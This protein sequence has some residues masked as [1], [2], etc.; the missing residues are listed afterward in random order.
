M[1][2]G[3]LAGFRCEPGHEKTSCCCRLNHATYITHAFS[4]SINVLHHAVQ[5]TCWN[6]THPARRWRS[7]A[8]LRAR[9]DDFC[10]EQDDH[11]QKFHLKS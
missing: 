2:V 7:W 8:A 9:E 10:A 11:V 6:A 5:Q 3:A 1:E 4:T